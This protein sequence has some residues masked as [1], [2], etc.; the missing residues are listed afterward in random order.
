[1][2]GIENKAEVYLAG[3]LIPLIRTLV[4]RPL[5]RDLLRTSLTLTAVALG[6]AVVIGIELAGDAAA[7]SF[8]SSLTTIVGK[9]DLRI[10]ANGGVDERWMGKLSTLPLNA[11]F[12][13]VMERAVRIRARGMTTLYG[14]D[15]MGLGDS[16]VMVS[17][18]LAQRLGFH[19]GDPLTLNIGKF[20]IERVADDARGGEFVAMDIAAA[21]FALNAY[22]KLDRIEVEISPGEDYRKVETTIREALPEG[23]LLD[24]PGARSNEN[25]RMLRAFR[26]NLRVLSYISLLVGAILIYNTIS[27]SVVRR[28]VEIGILRALGAAR[29]AVFAMFM[30]EALMFGVTGSTLG[31]ALGRLMAVGLVGLISVTVNSLYTSSSPASIELTWQTAIMAAASGLVVALGAA[32]GPA[33][34]A[35]KV[36]PREAMA[37]GSGEQRAARRTSVYLGVGMALGIG[38]YLAAQREPVNG[39]PL[40]GYVAVVLAIGAASL[41]APALTVGII[42][43]TKG[44]IR[45]VLGVGGL[46]AVQGLGSSLGRTSVVVAA[47]STAIAMMASVAI[48]VGSFRQTVIVWLDAQLR[49]DIYVRAAGPSAPGVFPPIPVEAEERVKGIAGVEAVD[50]F[51]G[52]EIRY[53]GSRADLGG[54]DPD[55]LLRY[56]RLKFLPG[57]NRD[58]VIRSLKGQNRVAITQAFANKNRLHVDDRMIVPLGDRRA[59]FTVAGIYY[60]YTSERGF[61]TVDRAVLLKYLPGQP[62]TNLAIY[63]R[64]GADR[65]AILQQVRNSLAELEVTAA[66]NE[67]LRSGAIEIFDRTFAV[68]WALEGVAIL[69]AMLGAANSLLAM[70]LDRRREFGLLRYLGGSAAQI[71]RTVLVEAGLVGMLANIL[72]STLGFALSLVL[73]YVINVQSFGWS[74][75]FHPPALPLAGALLLV[76]C[77]TIVAGLYPA[78]VASRLNPMDVIHTE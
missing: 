31:I 36:T 78:L 56:G 10:S 54:G 43:L 57:E 22:G 29:F 24:K 25:Q 74:I 66:P 32:F 1:V 59:A 16:G 11:R 72:G 5:G 58:D 45:K 67:T 7:G 40:F 73:I 34:E 50:V 51:S 26:W 28:R 41:V 71:R 35:M 8:Q 12:S 13:P 63:L 55:I 42:G 53:G 20:R 69:V 27:I 39:S 61:V 21:Q 37:R 38:A 76:W 4:L 47:L 23:Y 75:Q 64:T 33:W 15:A 3:P 2:S 65:E 18:G 68:T 52:I 77:V 17:G 19:K 70:V 44:T 46:I 60:D 9:T 30:V 14:I 62:P 6:V 49:A 48:M